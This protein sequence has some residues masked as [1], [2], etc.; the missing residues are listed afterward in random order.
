MNLHPRYVLPVFLLIVFSV[1]ILLGPMLYLVLEPWGIP[2]HR[3][4]SRA[5]L[6]SALG[7]L[8]LFRRRLQ[9]TAWWPCGARAWM[10]VGLGVL[11]AA[12]SAQLMIAAYLA[13]CGFSS[14]HLSAP[15]A[16][17]KILL[18]LVAALIVPMLEE[19]IFRG[20]LVTTLVEAAG[21]RAGWIFAAAIYAVAH[22]LRVPAGAPGEP[23]HPW[24]G[25]TGVAEIFTHL[26]LGEFLSGHGFNLFLVGLI[27][28]G[29]FSAGR[30]VVARRRAARGMDLHPHELHRAYSP[31]PG[32]TLR[33]LSRR[34][35]G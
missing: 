30:N 7:A 6:I 1:P 31:R 8:F 12:V 21:K 18:A 34:P 17:L 13:A 24:S 2:F 10:Q 16:G 3:T 27:L 32:T 20:F 23:I 9:L 28:G 35:A 11:V 33:V 4:M 15:A 22:F 29:V 25:A 14:A 5:L 19:T 26:G